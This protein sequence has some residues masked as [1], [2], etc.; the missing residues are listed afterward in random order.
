MDG[1]MD[2]HGQ[3]VTLENLLNFGVYPNP[4]VGLTITFP[5]PLALRNTALYN[6]LSLARGR[7]RTS[8]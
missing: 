1:W 3:G 2:G 5:L 8:L 7:H 6:I 4:D